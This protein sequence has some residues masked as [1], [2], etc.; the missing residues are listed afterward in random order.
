M[1]N[2]TFARHEKA[3]TVLLYAKPYD[4][5]ERPVN[6]FLQTYTTQFINIQQ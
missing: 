6:L 3:D 5:E 2:D 1:P 4:E